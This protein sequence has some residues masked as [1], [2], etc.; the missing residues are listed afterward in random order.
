MNY[1]PLSPC[2][3]FSFE[4]DVLSS[5]PPPPSPP[6]PSPPP[7]SISLLQAGVVPSMVGGIKQIWKTEG[8]PGFF[9]GYK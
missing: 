8:L 5:H 9:T 6:P 7:P 4:V 1:G 2:S 3:R